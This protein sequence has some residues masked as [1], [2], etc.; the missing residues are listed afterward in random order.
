[1]DYSTYPISFYAYWGKCDQ[2]THQH[3]LLAYHALDVAA[4]ASM[5]MAPDK[6]LCQDLSEF[7]QVEPEELCQIF[8]FLMTMHDLGKFSDAFQN[9]TT[10]QPYKDLNLCAKFA[11]D[12]SV[13]RHDRL[14]H[15][16]LNHFITQ[17]SFLDTFELR[18]AYSADRRQGDKFLSLLFGCFFGHHGQPVSIHR[19]DLRKLNQFSHTDNFQHALDFMHSCLTFMPCKLPIHWLDDEMLARLKQ[20]SWHF[21]GIGVIAD[22]LGSNVDYFSYNSSLMPL[23]DYWTIAC[24]Q[25]QN[26]IA[27][28]QLFQRF[29]VAPFQGFQKQFG[30][31]PSPLQSW[32]QDLVLDEG[33]QLFILEDTTGSG[34]TEAALT[35]AHRLMESDQADGFYFGLP[36]MATSNAMYQRVCDHYAKMYPDQQPS[37]VLAHSSKKMDGTFQKSL[38]KA[39]NDSYHRQDLST[40]A[41]CHA[42]FAD[43]NR[44]A[45][46]APLGVGTVDQALMSVI[47]MRYQVLRMIGLHRKVI[48]FDE[49]HA[50]DAYMLEL[51]YD[52]IQLHVR[53]GGSV[54]LLTATLANEQRTKL[55]QSF[56]SGLALDRV[57]P[58]QTAFPLASYVSANQVLSQP[59][60]PSDRSTKQ[61]QVHFLHSFDLCIETC[62]EQAHQGQSVV[63]V[64]NTI[65]DAM[66]AYQILQEQVDCHLFH[67]RFILADRQKI[68]QKVL[69]HLGKQSTE[70]QRRG[71]VVITTQVFQESLDA[72]ADVMIS[73]LCPVDDLIQRAGRLHRHTRD[74]KGQ[75]A[76][77]ESR[78]A[79]VLLV[80]APRWQD[81]PEPNWLTQDFYGSACI[82]G[83]AKLWLTMKVLRELNQIHIPNEARTLIESV[84]SSTAQEMI[85]ES[86]QDD[87]ALQQSE[88]RR[89]E[90]HADLIKLSWEKGYIPES[91]RWMDDTL[92]V[93]SR[94]IEV[95]TD[96]VVLIKK[97]KESYE[98][99]QGDVLFSIPLSTVRVTR[100]D[101]NQLC[102]LSDTQ[103][104]MFIKKYPQAKYKKLWLV[105]NDTQYNYNDQVGFF[106]NAH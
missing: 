3:H 27:E 50:A 44:K 104:K 83:S 86:L 80:H 70:I 6:P 30:F 56:Q 91:G 13:G 76:L 42:W 54:I 12:G 65:K 14:G 40:S 26:A 97:H 8:T 90:H 32:A 73:D 75:L 69:N 66:Q 77:K 96:E 33:P 10:F 74:I 51:I 24:Q 88:I 36:T 43:S 63:W 2:T 29:E 52:L 98:P 35:L 38:S 34:K 19:K 82:Y 22:W 61:V 45:L 49:I 71:F 99:W 4:V 37:L 87:A 79:P 85:P 18:Q 1:M 59:I 9:L 15:S 62:I 58:E 105:E 23:T 21:A 102:T 53:Q 60:H 17:S 16:F 41:S 48:I 11:Y 67:A 39:Q 100:K 93:G 84:Y 106:K 94:F 20:V 46:L 64:R 78:Q 28:T 55:L 101:A 68:E 89:R 57:I 72:D 5:L 47:P 103:D 95:E 92:E 81:E 25:A 7:L 31:N